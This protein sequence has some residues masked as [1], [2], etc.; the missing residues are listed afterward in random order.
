M[1]VD[2]Q[3][4]TITVAAQATLVTAQSRP[5]SCPKL[6][7]LEVSHLHYK[8]PPGG[9]AHDQPRNSTTARLDD[10]PWDMP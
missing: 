7:G 1:E 5:E 4:G 10:S 6:R 8:P 9:L 3:G 2:L